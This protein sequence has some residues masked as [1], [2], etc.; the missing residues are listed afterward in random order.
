MSY[1][2]R[3]LFRV[4]EEVNVRLFLPHMYLLDEEEP[5]LLAQCKDER[6]HLYRM[7]IIAI[8]TGMRKGD[9]LQLRWAKVDFQR[10]VIYVP[11]QK[12]GRDYTVPMNRDVR[13]VMLELKREAAVGAEF[14]FVNPKTNQAYVDIKKAFAWACSKA[15]IVDLHWHDLRHTFGTRLG[16]AGNSEA[17]IAELMGHTSV[18]TTRRYTHGTEKA[19]RA[20]VE[21]ARRRTGNPRPKYAPKEK[22][23]A[24]LLAVNT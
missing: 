23:P 12:T 11:N 24:L 17:T 10:N 6:A 9:Q 19:K 16:E 15:G 4:I 22:R 20:A 5:L 13:N 21:A 7:I 1:K 2:P 18:S 14:V 3:S 8:G